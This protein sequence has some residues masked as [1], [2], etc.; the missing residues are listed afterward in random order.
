MFIF[1]IHFKFRFHHCV[2]R[3]EINKAR[4]YLHIYIFLNELNLIYFE[5]VYIYNKSRVMSTRANESY[6]G[7]RPLSESK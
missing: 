3:D 2:L 6:Y 4:S 5:Y 1:A 7:L